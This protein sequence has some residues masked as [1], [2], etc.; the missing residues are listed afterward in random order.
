MIKRFS[1]ILLIQINK[2][3]QISSHIQVKTALHDIDQHLQE[4]LDD[5]D[6]AEFLIKFYLYSAIELYDK[7][8]GFKKEYCFPGRTTC[9][10]FHYH[11]IHGA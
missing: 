9:G 8:Y 4:S 11:R 1:K 6:W 5:K 2:I 10:C 3:L 7:K